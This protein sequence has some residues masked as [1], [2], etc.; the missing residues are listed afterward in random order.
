MIDSV[1]SNMIPPFKK[2]KKKKKVRSGWQGGDENSDL[3]MP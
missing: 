3:K 2:E 1:K